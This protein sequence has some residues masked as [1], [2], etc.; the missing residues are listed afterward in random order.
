MNEP[1]RQHLL[2]QFY[3]RGFADRRE[4]I[5]VFP[6][7]GQPGASKPHTTKITNVLVERDYYTITDGT[8]NESFIV[9]Q[10]LAQLE[11]AA[12]AALRVLLDEGLVLSDQQRSAWSEFM[13]MQVT[14]GRQFRQVWEDFSDRP[15]EGRPP[16]GGGAGARR[17]FRADQRRPR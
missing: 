4:R 8:G 16:R 7:A 5:N 12:S 6:R 3:L 1:R 15:D 10:A 11:A 14:R 17:V 2:P 13:A 9:E